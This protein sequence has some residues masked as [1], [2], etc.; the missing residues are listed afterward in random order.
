MFVARLPFA[1]SQALL[2]AKSSGA[3]AHVTALLV[4]VFAF[5]A[6]LKGIYNA[7]RRVPVVHVEI[8]IP[9]LPGTFAGFTIVQLSDI[10]VGRTIRKSYIDAIVDKV[11]TLDTNIVII[12]GHVVDGGVLD[13]RMDTAPMLRRRAKHCFYLVTGNHEY[14][15]ARIPGSRDSEVSDC[16]CF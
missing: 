15:Q 12:P 4:A 5:L 8:P 16:G 3:L 2:P 1:G 14:S 6:L 7:R 13:L 10:H 9:N 11:M